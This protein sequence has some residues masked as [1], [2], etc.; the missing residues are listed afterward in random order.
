MKYKFNL[1]NEDD[2]IVVTTYIKLHNK[3]RY[4][5]LSLVLDTGASHTVI[6]LNMLLIAGYDRSLR[7][8]RNVKVQTANKIIEADKFTLDELKVMERSIKDFEITT[9]DFLAQDD[10]LSYDGVLGLDFFKNTELNIDF[11]KFELTIT[12]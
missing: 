10:V 11:K 2:L 9:Y 5:P 12:L 3:T 7:L 6:D 8:N 1:P 4:Y